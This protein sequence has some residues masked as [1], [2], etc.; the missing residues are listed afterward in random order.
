MFQARVAE[1]RN[2]LG[3]LVLEEVLVGPEP[4]LEAEL[5]AGS[6]LCKK[7]TARPVRNRVT[8]GG[9]LFPEPTTVHPV[10]KSP[11]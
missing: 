2:T 9:E 10:K 4:E 8:V 6:P 11:T 7:K 5:E 3:E 1:V